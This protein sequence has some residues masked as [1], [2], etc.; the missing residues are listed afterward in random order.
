VTATAAEAPPPPRPTPPPPPA[1]A[2]PRPPKPSGGDSL[3][4]AELAAGVIAGRLKNPRT[5]L[6]ATG[7]LGLAFGAIGYAIGRSR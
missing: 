4:A 6:V 2:G 7:A 1:A 3:N 5:L